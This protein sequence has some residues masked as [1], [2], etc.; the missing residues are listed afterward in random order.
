MYDSYVMGL[1]SARNSFGYRSLRIRWL[2]PL[3]L[4]SYHSSSAFWSREPVETRLVEPILRP[5]D[6]NFSSMK[7]ELCTCN[8]T[9]PKIMFLVPC[10]LLHCLPDIWPAST[11]FY[12]SAR[13]TACH[14]SPKKS[15][16]KDIKEVAKRTLFGHM[17][18]Y[19]WFLC[20]SFLKWKQMSTFHFRNCWLGLPNCMRGLFFRRW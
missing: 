12:I 8:R 16:V 13:L 4:A 15:T 1:C 14:A 10:F 17:F 3:P 5:S 2:T 19:V 11:A 9:P 18:N 6:P 20:V 7:T